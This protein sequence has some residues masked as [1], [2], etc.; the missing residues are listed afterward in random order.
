MLTSIIIINM[1]ILFFT[2]YIKVKLKQ[3][4][5]Q[6]KILIPNIKIEIKKYLD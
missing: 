1:K 6:F 3:L 4:L 2:Q 5:L